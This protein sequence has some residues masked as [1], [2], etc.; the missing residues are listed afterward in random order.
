MLAAWFHLKRIWNGLSSKKVII[1][2]KA[3]SPLL[4]CKVGSGFEV[5]RLCSIKLGLFSFTLH[6]DNIHLLVLVYVDDIIISGNNSKAIQVFK[7]YLSDYF[8]MKDLGPLKY[9]LGIEVARNPTG[10]FLS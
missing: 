7:M 9:F 3:S 5:L 10:I 2:I 4:I 1:W 6:R 8:Y